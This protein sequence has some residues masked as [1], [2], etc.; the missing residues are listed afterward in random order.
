MS[1]GGRRLLRDGGDRLCLWGLA[2]SN[3]I[4]TIDPV[5]CGVHCIADFFS[6]DAMVAV[7][8]S[9]ELAIWSLTGELQSRIPL[10]LG[11]VCAVRTIP[12]TKMILLAD[13]LGGIYRFEPA[14]GTLQLLHPRHEDW[15]RSL[16][17]SSDGRWVLSVSQEQDCRLYDLERGEL[18]NGDDLGR[19]VS[20]A[21][22][23]PGDPPS[24]VTV[25]ADGEIRRLSL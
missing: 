12:H 10:K 25:T 5:G 19:G 22:F 18:V 3:L 6:D 17:V 9:G 20:C 2:E 14:S 13:P 1:R 23:V 21:D 11:Y 7:G 24:I 4:G 8:N 15:I 16:D